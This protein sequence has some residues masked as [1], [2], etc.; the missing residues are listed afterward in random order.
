MNKMGKLRTACLNLSRG[1]L[2]AVS[3]V[4]FDRLYYRLKLGRPCNLKNPTRLSEKIVWLKRY[5]HDEQAVVCA[6]KY[7][8]RQFLQEMGYGELLIPLL[9]VYS[10]PEEFDPDLLPQRFILKAAHGSGMNFIC[11]DKSALN[12]EEVKKMIKRW[13]NTN[14]YY[15]CAESHYA[16][17]PRRVVC[18]ALLEEPGETA[19]TDYKFFCFHGQPQ[20]VMV[21]YGRIGH[22]ASSCIYDLRWNKLPVHAGNRPCGDREIPCPKHFS[23]M[24]EIAKDLSAGSPVLRVDLYEVEGHIYFGELTYY[25]TAGIC[26]F[27]PDIYDIIFGR[28]LTLPEK[29][30]KKFH[31]EKE[32]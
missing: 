8:V 2:I 27:H 4:S 30:M 10:S 20:F 1:G 24:L 26:S 9:D 7:A 18:E 28:G 5:W 17:M 21:F 19:P 11:R 25:H 3:P 16:H 29:R 32:R 23:K 15:Q 22:I 6:D 14:Y 12:P 31:H 13:L